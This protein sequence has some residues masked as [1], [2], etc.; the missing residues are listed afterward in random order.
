MYMLTVYTKDWCGYCTMAKNRLTEWNIQYEEIN[1]DVDKDARNFIK[2]QG[3]N[4]APQIFYNGKLF[5][6]DGAD[7]LMK[8][9]LIEIKERLGDL[10]LSDMSL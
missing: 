2:E 4:T 1:M 9:S 6:S 3:L 8:M 7:G 5:V 10:D